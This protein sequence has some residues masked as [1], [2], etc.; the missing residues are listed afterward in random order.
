[1]EINEKQAFWK[2]SLPTSLP[3]QLS[4]LGYTTALWYGGSLSWSSL[5]L[6]ARGMGF[7]ETYSGLDICGEDAPQTWL[8]IYDHIFLDA[9]AKKL[10]EYDDKP[11]FH[12]IY[13]TSNH[14]PY[15]I[16]IEKYGFSPRTVL[17]EL[18]ESMRKNKSLV[19]DLG[20]YWYS[21]RS[22]GR[23]VNNVRQLY[24]DCLII[25]TGD[26]SRNII[27]FGSELY[28]KKEA[29]V[30]EKYCTSFSLYHREFTKE[31]FRTARIGGHMNILPTLIEA[32]APQGFEYYSLMPSFFELFDHAITPY[33]WLTKK[34]IGFFDDKIAQTLE[35]DSDIEQNISEFGEL[36]EAYCEVTGWVIRHKNNG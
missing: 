30:R 32:I 33:H 23:F 3:R 21:D 34:R 11:Y 18:P 26:H 5:G 17:S 12:F 16:P 14:G 29:T 9:L 28:P 4:S 13:T 10:S 7:D 1:M 15:T 22:L 19:A 6:F 20:T 27:P 35:A 36:R 2:D 8:G 24:P 25:V 31:L